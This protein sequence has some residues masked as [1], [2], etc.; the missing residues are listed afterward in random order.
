[1]LDPEQEPKTLDPWCWSQGQNLKY[2][3]WLHNPG[4]L[5][6]PWSHFA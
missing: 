1:M 6:G 5:C 4:S 3:F 2:E